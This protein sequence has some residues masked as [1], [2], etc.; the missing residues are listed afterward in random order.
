MCLGCDCRN[1]SRSGEGGS[2]CT[3]RRDLRRLSATDATRRSW[4]EAQIPRPTT[5][6]RW[7]SPRCPLFSPNPRRRTGILKL[8]FVRGQHGAGTWHFA[9]T[10]S[11]GSPSSRTTSATDT[12]NF[13][14]V[15]YTGV[16]L[17]ASTRRKLPPRMP[18]ISSSVYP[19]RI[20]PSVRS[21]MR[22]GW[23]RPSM[24]TLSRKA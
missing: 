23:F 7:R 21:N 14:C 16:Q 22:R 18:L 8:V 6:A 1:T 19:R 11:S 5:P 12:A 13:I 17:L 4:P 2:G 15:Y 20:R 24:S 9:R 3:D 10:Q